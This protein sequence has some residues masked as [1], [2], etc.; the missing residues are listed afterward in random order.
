MA[1]YHRF[2]KRV[3]KREG[4]KI[5]LSIAQINEVIKCAVEEIVTDYSSLRD[6]N[7]Y[8]EKV[9]SNLNRELLRKSRSSKLQKS[10]V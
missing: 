6:F 10:K 1:N 8:V 7:D 2:T 9:R 4:G 5:N 3:A